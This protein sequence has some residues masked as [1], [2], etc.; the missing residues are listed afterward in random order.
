MTDPSESKTSAQSSSKGGGMDPDLEKRMTAMFRQIAAEMSSKENNPAESTNAPGLSSAHPYTDKPAAGRMAGS[1]TAGPATRTSNTPV[2]SVSLRSPAIRRAPSRSGVLIVSQPGM[3]AEHSAEQLIQSAG[4]ASQTLAN[5]AS[6]TLANGSLSSDIAANPGPPTA[7]ILPEQQPAHFVEQPFPS[8]SSELADPRLQAL[9]QLQQTVSPSNPQTTGSVNPVTGAPLSDASR[10]AQSVFGTSALQPPS[11]IPETSV[12]G[13]PTPPVVPPA[14]VFQPP[15]LPR[16]LS[17]DTAD[18]P[19]PHQVHPTP[20]GTSDPV[21]NGPVPIGKGPV[22]DSPG[23]SYSRQPP[24]GQPDSIDPNFSQQSRPGVPSPGYQ[25][26]GHYPGQSGFRATVESDAPRW[27]HSYQD[28]AAR[29]GLESTILTPQSSSHMPIEFRPW[30]DS[31]VRNH[32]G[33]AP[34]PMT[35]DAAG[36]VRQAML[37]SPQILALQAE[38]EVQQRIVWQEEAQFDWRTFLETTYDD[39]NDPVGNRLTTGDLSDRFKDNKFSTIGGF[40]KKTSSGGELEVS[41]RVGHQYNNSTYLVPNPQSTSRLELSFR[42]PVWNGAG[43]IYSQSQIVLARITTNSSSDEVLAELQDHLYQVTEAYWQLYRSRAE[44][45]QRQKLVESA[46]SVLQTLEGR[47]QVDTVPRQ[48]LRARAAVARA[49]AR[50]QRAVTAIRNTES[51]LRLLVNDPAMLNQ[52]PVEFMPTEMPAM[53]PVAPVLHDSLNTAL[54]N[55]PDISRAIRQMRASGVRLGVSRNEMLPKLDFLVKTYVAGLEAKDRIDTSIANQFTRGQPG[56]TVGFEFEV[57]LGNRAAR[58][59]Y[60]QRKW[61]LQRSINVFRATVEASLTEVEVANREVETAYREM[62]GRYQ[63]MVAAQN[64]TNYLKDRFEVLPD[65]EDSAILLLEDL[66]DGFERLADEESTFVDAQVKYALSIIKLRQ[67][68]GVLLRSRHDS[69]ETLSQ[70]SEWMAQRIE[71][72]MHGRVDGGTNVVPASITATTFADPATMPTDARSNQSL[73]Y[74][75]TTWAPVNSSGG[76]G[77]VPV[78]HPGNANSVVAPS[79]AIRYSPAVQ[80]SSSPPVMNGQRIPSSGRLQSSG[81]HSLTG[82]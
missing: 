47:D 51:Q 6:Q 30:W 29:M 54:I 5:S 72:T 40:R 64:E 66:L 58:A 63:A 46:R 80:P 32:M 74:S 79:P 38:P 59:R 55:R 37:Y 48:I 28:R 35:V 9:P 75:Q 43:S 3:M 62:Q 36:L 11:A 44:F 33:I 18:I 31:L 8:V 16:G 4:E 2:S 21:R 67:V 70:H 53:I 69:P 45:Y 24:T 57:P 10:I 56:Y 61:E 22:G 26:S 49:E 15:S 65:A 73:A 60:E 50:M 20:E 12:P 27:L 23:P 17:S 19:L 52:G 71:E 82:P 34:T 39:L 25:G 14:P 81:G 1:V 68:T 76:Q 77:S 42:Q 13:N 41:Q 78:N 7:G